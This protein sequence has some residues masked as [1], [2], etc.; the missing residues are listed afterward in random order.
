MTSAQVAPQALALVAAKA[1][2]VDIA[3][4]ASIG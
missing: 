3:L 2:L 4:W 1:S